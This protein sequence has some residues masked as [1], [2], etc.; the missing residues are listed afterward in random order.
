MSKNPANDLVNGC[1]QLL[2]LA[3]VP[4]WRNSTTGVYDPAK[5]RF[6]KFVGRKG[7]SDI[8]GLV[9]PSGRIIAVECKS[10]TGRL[11]P[12]QREFLADINANGGIGVCVHSIADLESF[13][14]G[15][16]ILGG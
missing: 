16:G 14:R 3:K 13:L 11:T 4:A 8:L 15:H 2:T 1:L 9:P 12:E 5:Q 7:V 10:G 6:R